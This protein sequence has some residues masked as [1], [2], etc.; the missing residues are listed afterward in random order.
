MNQPVIL[1]INAINTSYL[2]DIEMHLFFPKSNDICKKICNPKEQIVRNIFHVHNYLEDEERKYT[3]LKNLIENELYFQNESIYLDNIKRIFSNKESM[4][5]YLNYSKYDIFH[6]LNIFKNFL[7][8]MKKLMITNI[9]NIVYN[10]KIKYM[11]NSEFVYVIGRDKKFRPIIVIDFRNYEAKILKNVENSHFETDLINT[12]L[13]FF[14]FVIEKMLL[15]GQTEQLNLIMQIDNMSATNFIHNF[16]DIIYFLQICYPSRLHL[17]YV[18]CFKN[19][20]ESSYNLIENFLFFF[21]KERIILINKKKYSAIFNEISHKTLKDLL[22]PLINNFIPFESSNDNQM[23]NNFSGTASSI[24]NMV[25][26]RY[27]DE[28]VK[29]SFPPFVDKNLIFDNEDEKNKILMKIDDYMSFIEDKKFFYMYNEELFMKFKEIVDVSGHLNDAKCD[30]KK[31]NFHKI[32]LNIKDN[33]LSKREE[34]LGTNYQAIVNANIENY[35]KIDIIHD[36]AVIKQ[37]LQKDIIVKNNL[38]P[39]KAKNFIHIIKS[40]SKNT[41]K[42]QVEPANFNS[43]IENSKEDINIENLKTAP[44]NGNKIEKIE[45]EIIIETKIRSDDACC[46]KSNCVIN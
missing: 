23:I 4:M 26:Q 21:N 35:N 10:D 25:N 15:P 24:V 8:L 19:I 43:I 17:M 42:R 3:N 34:D 39:T 1:E 30:V 9:Y 2:P 27:S 11:L 31:D 46:I 18:V 33:I 41:A 6:T 40:N 5:R 45:S 28:N 7:D 13:Y 36:R 38:E 12:L 20:S 32:K 37:K 14:N 22:D 44:K 16:K 29:Y